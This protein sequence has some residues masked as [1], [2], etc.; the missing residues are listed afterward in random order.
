M[1]AQSR[2]M[3][4]TTQARFDTRPWLFWVGVASLVFFV[5]HVAKPSSLS[6]IYVPLI[7][8]LVGV[9]VVAWLAAKT[10]PSVAFQ[11]YCWAALF[12]VAAMVWVDV[13]TGVPGFPVVVSAPAVVTGIIRRV[14]TRRAAFVYGLAALPLVIVT[15]II[16]NDWGQAGA[17]AAVILLA[18]ITKRKRQSALHQPAPQDLIETRDKLQGLAANV[19]T[20]STD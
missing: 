14:I 16:Y 12:V 20:T 17:C 11:S 15:G 5:P 10:A 18:V 8:V 19:S 2:G 7:G 9:N 4:T 3:T 13:Q 6:Y 1:A